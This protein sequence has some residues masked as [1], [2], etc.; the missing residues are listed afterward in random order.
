MVNLLTLTRMKNFFAFLLILFLGFSA[1]AG[2]Y[3]ILFCDHIDSA[4]GKCKGKAEEFKWT[5]DK[6]TLATVVINKDRL[7]TTK[8]NYKVFFMKNDR[9]GELAAELSAKTRA[10]WFSVTKKIYFFKPGYYKVDVYN[11]DN[12][13]IVSGFVTISDRDVAP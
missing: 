5:G 3:E 10:S 8:I 13:L 7:N 2:S 12:K 6:M 9:E 11:A 1:H 4:S